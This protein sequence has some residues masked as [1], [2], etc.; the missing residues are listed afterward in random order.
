MHTLTHICAPPGGRAA[1]GLRPLDSW[2]RGVGIPKGA[3]T[4][5]SCV[6]SEGSDLSNELNHSFGGVAQ[7]VCVC[8]CVRVRV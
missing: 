4:F 7:C 6:C 8:V 3:W 5:V 2:Y 1:K